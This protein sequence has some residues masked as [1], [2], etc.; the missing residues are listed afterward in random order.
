M[1]KLI[2][3]STCMFLSIVSCTKDESESYIK[4][5]QA[6]YFPVPTGNEAVDLGLS[7][8][9]APFN[10]GASS[11]EE[12]GNYYAWGETEFKSEYDSLT[13]QYPDNFNADNNIVGTSH[14][15]AH[16]NWGK[17]WRLPTKSEVYELRNSCPRVDTVINNVRGMLYISKNGNSIFLPAAGIYI[18]DNIVDKG[19]K[20]YYMNGVDTICRYA[21]YFEHDYL[22][23]S[24]LT[25]RPVLDIQCPIE[26]QTIEQ[27]KEDNHT[28]SDWYYDKYYIIFK[29]KYSLK[30]K[31]NLQN[32]DIEEFGLVFYNNDK[33]YKEI[34][35]KNLNEEQV[36]FITIN[37]EQ[38]SYSK[39]DG[40]YHAT[41]KG[42]WKIST[43]LV[44]NTI[45]GTKKIYSN[46]IT[47]LDFIYN[48]QPEITIYDLSEG[49]E[50]D[51]D[52]VPWEDKYGYFTWKQSTF[53]VNVKGALFM[54]NG[55]EVDI[56][57]ATP[58]D[59][60]NIPYDI[61]T[62]ELRPH[63][64]SG[65]S[66]WND[67]EHLFHVD[68]ILTFNESADNLNVA[69]AKFKSKIEIP[70]TLPSAITSATLKFNFLRG[71]CDIEI[72]N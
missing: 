12:Y 35:C 37:A 10:I 56:Q 39:P 26:I 14:D 51:F 58:S 13:Y 23:S 20:G 47:D 45:T 42:F 9:W 27:I 2:F 46:K 57:H 8:K 55:Y 64:T 63:S 67:G 41:T 33:I 11:P 61:E 72:V 17:G 24:G 36:D 68:L 16:V 18:D 50:T 66:P 62:M 5:E 7:V 71:K 53:K 6:E 22:K 43:Y 38:I 21:D 15:V 44:F 28:Y 70:G 32:S 48:S 49:S 30:S 54:R 60:G 4:I 52:D 3:F 1:R 69:R 40:K 34:K 65:A 25:V 29:F 59:K 31:E 19:I